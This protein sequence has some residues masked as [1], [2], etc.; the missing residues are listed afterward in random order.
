[1]YNIRNGAIRWQMH[2]F[3]FDGNSNVC[4]ISHHLRDIRKSNKMSKLFDL[5]TE[6][7]GQGGE[8]RDLCHSPGNVRFHM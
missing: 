2:D 5:E 3:L 7:Q 1:M 4:S 8:K 6:G